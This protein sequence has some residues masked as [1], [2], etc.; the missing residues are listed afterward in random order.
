VTAI[1]EYVTGRN[2]NVSSA[3][4]ARPTPALQSRLPAQ[5][6]ATTPRMQSTAATVRVVS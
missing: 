3:A 1:R 2:A 6:T 4:A 5:N